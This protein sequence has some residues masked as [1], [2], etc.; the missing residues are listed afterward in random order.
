MTE[1]PTGQ[2]PLLLLASRLAAR[3]AHE[4]NNV[5]AV[6]IGHLYLLRSSKDPP[7]ESY[8]AMETGLEHLQK[9]SRSLAKLAALGEGDTG[10]FDLNSAVRSTVRE[11]GLAASLELEEGVGLVYG[12]ESDVRLALSAL[13]DNARE[14]SSE[15]GGVRVFTRTDASASRISVGV[16]DSTPG[17]LVKR[18][19]P[20]DSLFTTTGERGRGLGLTLAASVAA[21]HGG[22]IEIEDRKE[23]TSVSLHFPVG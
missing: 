23:G 3:T 13:L 17:P 21:A 10:S 16:E 7:E 6:L 4:L 15:R 12:R 5:A 1:G 22:E 14:A 20:L 2:E 9:I 18:A 11:N 19:R 8:A